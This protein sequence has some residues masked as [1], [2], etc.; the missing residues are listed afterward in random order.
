[1]DHNPAQGPPAKDQGLEAFWWKFLLI[2]CR[3]LLG[4][5]QLKLPDLA[6]DDSIE[7]MTS[8]MASLQA[9]SDHQASF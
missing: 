8:A 9:L 1:M 3:N 7:L 6:V 5:Q 4:L 2:W